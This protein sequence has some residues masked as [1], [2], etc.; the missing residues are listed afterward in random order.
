MPISEWNYK[1]EADT[2]RHIGP[3]AQD[4]YALFGVGADD[5][6]ISTVDPA[7]VALVA[8]KELYQRNQRLEQ[9]LSELRE[10][11]ERLR[12]AAGE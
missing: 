2:I 11:V 12:A 1:K 5:K 6:S 9:E 8:I 7:G 4:F 3:V 10:L